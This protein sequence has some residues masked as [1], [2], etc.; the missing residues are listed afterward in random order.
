MEGPSDD[1]RRIHATSET[2]AGRSMSSGVPSK[3]SGAAIDYKGSN[4][5]ICDA[6]LG[7]FMSAFS[8]KFDKYNTRNLVTA[9]CRFG[10]DECNPASMG[11]YKRKRRDFFCMSLQR[12][13]T[14]MQ[15]L[16]VADVIIIMVAIARFYFRGSSSRVSRKD[17]LLT[18][19][20]EHQ[21]FE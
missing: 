20:P 19:T 2:R 4:Q 16:G 21:C 12:V 14:C 10:K 7:K 17:N 9:L 11:E 6:K 1:N 15:E 5:Q 18:D 3:N 8:H 13:V